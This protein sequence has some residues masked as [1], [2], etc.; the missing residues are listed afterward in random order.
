MSVG[1]IDPY[2]GTAIAELPPEPK[3]NKIEDL[4]ATLGEFQIRES[5]SKTAADID[6]ATSSEDPRAVR[7]MQ[8]TL[9][10]LKSPHRPQSGTCSYLLIDLK[11]IQD[12]LH[13]FETLKAL[14]AEANIFR[15]GHES[16]VNV[17]N[18]CLFILST[19]ERPEKSILS[20]ADSIKKA[21]PQARIFS[22]FGKTEYNDDPETGAQAFRVKGAP[23][24][25]VLENWRQKSPGIY[26]TMNLAAEIKD[27]ERRSGSGCTIR[28]QSTNDPHIVQLTDYKATSN[29]PKSGPDQTIGYIKEAK[30]L[31]DFTRDDESRFMIVKGEGG[32]GKSRILREA[33]EDTQ[34][35]TTI[36]SLDA[37]DRNMHGASLVTLADQLATML[38]D[39]N[40]VNRYAI[41]PKIEATEA[42]PQSSDIREGFERPSFKTLMSRLSSTTPPAAEHSQPSTSTPVSPPHLIESKTSP[43][44]SLEPI[45]PGTELMDFF[46]KSKPA[47]ISFAQQHPEKLAQMCEEALKVIIHFKGKKSILAIED[48]HNSDKF[49]ERYISQVGKTFLRETDGQGKVVISMRPEE[50]Y[51][52]AT[53]KEMKREINGLYGEETSTKEIELKGL[54]FSKEIIAYRYIWHSLPENIRTNPI[55]KAPKALGEWFKILATAAGRSP[56]RMSAFIGTIKE[57]LDENLIVTDDVINVKK[58][59]LDEIEALGCEG[60]LGEYYRSRINRIDDRNTKEILNSIALSG[61]R[62]TEFQLR[63]II[64]KV[65][66]GAGTELPENIEEEEH[67]K[68]LISGA[69]I[70]RDPKNP[71]IFRMQH[72]KIGEYVVQS[73]DQN[74]KLTL[75]RFLY[76][77]VYTEDPNVHPETKLA[78]LHTIA[79]H[80]SPPPTV[81]GSYVKAARACFKTAQDQKSIGKTYALAESILH[82]KRGVSAVRD[83]IER[84]LNDEEV[85]HPKLVELAIEALFEKAKTAMFLGKFDE[86]ES[87]AGSV[88]EGQRKKGLLERLYDKKPEAFAKLDIRLSQIHLLACENAYIQDKRKAMQLLFNETIEKA[89]DREISQTTKKLTKMKL[90]YRLNKFE[91]ALKIWEGTKASRGVEEV[92]GLKEELE[93]DNAVYQDT[94]YRPLPDYLEGR[95]LAEIRIPFERIRT[96]VIK[97][98][99]ASRPEQL[100]EDI[101]MSSDAWSEAAKEEIATTIIPA[102]TEMR[103]I[104]I[105][106]PG[107]FNVYAEMSTMEINDQIQAIGGMPH[108]AAVG[109]SEI[110]RQAE[111]IEFHF[112]AVRA[113]KMKGDLQILRGTRDKNP[114]K[115]QEGIETY[116]REGM[117]ALSEI[118]DTDFRQISMRIQR[119]RGIGRLCTTSV[120]N[121]FDTTKPQPQI[122]MRTQ[123]ELRPYIQV[124]LKDFSTICQILKA[125]QYQNADLSEIS[126]YLMSYMAFIIK[127]AQRTNTELPEDL[128]DP[129]I[130]QLMTRNIVAKGQT[131]AANTIDMGVIDECQIK[132]EG[133]F[134]MG[135]ILAV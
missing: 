29:I 46:A 30:E 53:I 87:L 9:F 89:D 43:Q 116:S 28:V 32:I 44:I 2:A 45:T 7:S 58:E 16:Y 50:M 55:T 10:N 59:L 101:L 97:R 33:L 125:P 39:G 110:W 108:F 122:E 84:L 76:T 61:G 52:S 83:T 96:N 95:R 80:P 127:T 26:L 130:H 79:T 64:T 90:C 99:N 74:S 82:K 117:I 35:R 25:T 93:V 120:D 134:Q 115:V 4:E 41:E 78:L 34:D 48:M 23:S 104:Q 123:Q 36:C 22:G 51:E 106:H 81:W 20:S 66:T 113:A 19:A 135:E 124:A 57:K 24:E 60:D 3:L 119:I 121:I 75:A 111:H 114:F 86:I 21:I 65:A 6:L 118:A 56:L 94:N 8:Q 31:K 133:L 100:D 109:L 73:I 11:T 13:D 105:E 27:S 38:N 40:L 102:I 14:I 54:D 129:E 69:Y 131:F 126:Y 15:D 5:I 49:S 67:I 132:R 37:G 92:R 85:E 112:Q 68:P 98:P 47:K 17:Q 42:A 77:V 70:F 63:L 62:V 103:Q 88:E 107:S 128:F 12:Q 71:D 72:D 18:G 91:E 1:T